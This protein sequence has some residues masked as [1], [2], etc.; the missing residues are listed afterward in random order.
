MESPTSDW[1]FYPRS[2]KW[3]SNAGY[4]YIFHFAMSFSLCPL[5]R[6][7]S[8]ILLCL[9]LCV[10]YLY[11]N[12]K[13]LVLLNLEKNTVIISVQFFTLTYL[14]WNRFGVQGNKGNRKEKL[15]FQPF[16]IFKK[17]TYSNAHITVIVFCTARSKQRSVF[18]KLERTTITLFFVINTICT[19][20]Q[21]VAVVKDFELIKGSQRFV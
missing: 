13:V 15:Y 10:W 19:E 14:I 17:K 18:L 9:R 16:E 3:V 2:T 11:L 1:S 21:I 8:T 12:F 5:H 20:L 7:M 6:N 4:F